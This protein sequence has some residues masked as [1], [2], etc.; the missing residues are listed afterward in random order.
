MSHLQALSAFTPALCHSGY[1]RLGTTRFLS[2]PLG[3]MVTSFPGHLGIDVH[4]NPSLAQISGLLH[5]LPPPKEKLLKRL[6]CALSVINEVLSPPACRDA[7]HRVRWVEESPGPAP[8]LYISSTR[9]GPWCFPFA[10]GPAFVEFNGEPPPSG[11]EHFKEDKS[12]CMSMWG[13]GALGHH[14]I[15]G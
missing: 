5:P 10:C 13:F 7:L 2:I 11:S 12:T 8:W 15:S 4:C 1:H 9:H 14:P 6:L 3:K